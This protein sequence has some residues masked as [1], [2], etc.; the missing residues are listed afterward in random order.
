MRKTAAVWLFAL[1]LFS[2]EA[3]SSYPGY[4]LCPP[5][6]LARLTCLALEPRPCLHLRALFYDPV[7]SQELT[8]VLLL[9]PLPCGPCTTDSSNHLSVLLASPDLLLCPMDHNSPRSYHHGFCSYSRVS[10]IYLVPTVPSDLLAMWEEMFSF[11][12]KSNL[13]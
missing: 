8:S 10:G 11:P 9:P 2:W 6:C 3:A 7:S 13:D 5:D 12:G 4:W 1:R